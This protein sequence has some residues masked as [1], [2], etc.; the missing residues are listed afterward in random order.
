MSTRDP[1]SRRRSKLRRLERTYAGLR[2]SLG[3]VGYLFPGSVMKRFM[4]C[5]KPSCRCAADASQQ[6]GPYYDWTR[7]VGGKTVTVRLTEE[8][9]RLSEAGIQNR[10]KFKEIVARMQEIS[11]QIVDAMANRDL[12]R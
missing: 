7:K 8:Q 5:G 4:P 12:D 10:R 2:R 3:E 1:L 11:T 9:A 6:H